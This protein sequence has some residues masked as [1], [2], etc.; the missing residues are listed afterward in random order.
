MSKPLFFIGSSPSM[1]EKIINPS[2]PADGVMVSI[3]A[4]EKRS[5]VFKYSGKWILDSG[6]FT[7]ISTHGRYRQR[8]EDYCQKILK[9]AFRGDLLIAVSQDWMCEPF[10]L[11]RTGLNTAEHQRLTIERYKT[12]HALNP[13]VPI[14][15][16]IQG[17]TVS[18]YVKHLNDYGELLTKGQWVGVGSVCKRNSTPDEIHEILRTI[19]LVRPDVRLHGFGLKI[20]ALERPSIRDMLYSA[21]SMAWHYPRKFKPALDPLSIA[22]EYQVKINSPGKR[23]APKTAGAG[24]G[25][26][27]KP[28]WKSETE[29]VRL[30][31]R[32]I[33]LVLEMVK[34]WELTECSPKISEIET[35]TTIEEVTTTKKSE[36]ETVTAPDRRQ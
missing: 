8:V 28:K 9:Y 6:A 33:P 17:Y 20:L 25:Q 30:P 18:D 7:E 34:E 15:P 13:V 31:K 26:G 29:S 19:K 2:S 10:I 14:M 5:S 16:V 36:I 32:Y 24:N 3:N 21:D 12:L 22:H 4:L 23:Q 27:R 35:I 11:Q 1:A